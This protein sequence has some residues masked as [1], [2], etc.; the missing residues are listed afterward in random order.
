LKKV[1]EIELDAI[2]DTRLG[3]LNRLDPACSQRVAEQGMKYQSRL[4]D[5][6]S[7]IDPSVDDQR[8]NALYKARD[9]ET[10]KQSFMSEVIVHLGD[11][12]DGL[13]ARF[14]AGDPEV[15]SIELR[16]NIYPYRLT[17]EEE[18]LYVE[19]LSQRLLLTRAAITVVDV[20]PEMIDHNYIKG[21][22]LCL[23]FVYNYRDWVNRAFTAKEVPDGDPTVTVIAPA[24]V[25]SVAVA[26]ENWEKNKHLP[27][28]YLRDP[29]VASRLIMSSVFSVDFRP[30]SVFSLFD[31]DRFASHLDQKRRT[32]SPP[33]QT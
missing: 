21:N 4:S 16:L 6:F 30:A 12:L 26:R 18:R 2:I 32:G 7:Y 3:T 17:H 29:F 33:A 13:K 20:P 10:L 24:L 14:V 11:V 23:Y 8:Y 1:I 9:V 5:E 28:E 31:A 22:D 27:E 25:E 15:R 19:C